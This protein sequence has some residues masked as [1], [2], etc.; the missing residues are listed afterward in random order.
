METI[1][2]R[3]CDEHKAESRSLHAQLLQSR[4]QVLIPQ[5]MLDADSSKAT[6]VG[7]D[8]TLPSSNVELER[9]STPICVQAANDSSRLQHASESDEREQE[10]P[11][12]KM[13]GEASILASFCV[14]CSTCKPAETKA[15]LYVGSIPLNYIA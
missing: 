5:A 4:D 11:A 15:V 14:Q 2:Q 3:Q 9:M 13:Q 12:A 1:W 10:S 8:L 6:D 7:A